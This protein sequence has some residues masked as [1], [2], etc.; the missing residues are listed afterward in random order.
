MGVDHLQ[1]K[2]TG[3]PPGSKSTLAWLRDV[4]WAYRNVGKPDA[5]P[6]S[7]FAGLLVALM[8]EHPDRFLT[9]LALAEAQVLNRERK[10]MAK[11]MPSSVV[12]DDGQPRRL[13]RLTL[14][15]TSLFTVLR[16][17]TGRWVYGI[18][19]DA[20]VV[21]CEADTSQRALRLVIRSVTFPEVAEGEPI[22]ELERE[23]VNER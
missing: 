1:D 20:H 9:C 16:G 3:R 8:R 17:G 18:P 11:G 4:R 6:P 19:A 23:W 13:M 15:E 14:W 10:R 12:L 22:P 7:A 21:A 2:R 5:E